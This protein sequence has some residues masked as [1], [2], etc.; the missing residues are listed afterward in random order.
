[1]YQTT[2][3]ETLNS[4]Y[5]IHT[6]HAYLEKVYIYEYAYILRGQMNE[7][8]RRGNAVIME[9]KRPNRKRSNRSGPKY[10]EVR[11]GG[12]GGGF[13]YHKGID[14]HAPVIISTPTT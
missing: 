5:S 7:W 12:G 1:M 3:N 13:M 2:L 9:V 14:L 8:N 4:F 10:C 6:R 11:G